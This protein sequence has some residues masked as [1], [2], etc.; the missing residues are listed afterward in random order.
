MS[1][2]ISYNS[3]YKTE[4]SP[5]QREVLDLIGRGRTNQEI[6]DVLGITLNG[7]KYHVS[8]ILAKLQVATREDAAELWRAERRVSA[9]PGR[10]MQVLIGA[11]SLRPV[12][13]ALVL[14]GAAAAAAGIALLVLPVGGH[15]ASAERPACESWQMGIHGNTMLGDQ[16]STATVQVGAYALGG[17]SCTY[18]GAVTVS[19]IDASGNPLDIDGNG[20]QVPVEGAFRWIRMTFGANHEP[21]VTNV[22]DPD[23]ARTVT[24]A[25]GLI[26]FD[27]NGLGMADE[28]GPVHNAVWW[29]WCGDYSGPVTVHITDVATGAS[30]PDA[31]FS[32]PPHC[33]D[34][35]KPSIVVADWR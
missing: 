32:N 3:R 10:W 13:G 12:M 20:L 28:G 15:N 33:D 21:T 17:R 11:L 25:H 23:G 14:G 30:A 19:F 5:R 7:A 6:A 9:R 24:A 34:P 26:V 2:P 31:Y 22:D 8:E 27:G 35:S 29:N 1:R 4:L 18:T 16:S